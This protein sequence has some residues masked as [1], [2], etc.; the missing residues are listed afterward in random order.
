MLKEAQKEEIQL[1]LVCFSSLEASKG[2]DLSEYRSFLASQKNQNLRLP[3]NI[4]E[5]I[6]IA[7]SQNYHT[8]KD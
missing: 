7:F 2:L 6:I 1:F 4:F 3:R 8:F 5:E